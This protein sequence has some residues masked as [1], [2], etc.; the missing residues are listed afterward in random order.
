MLYRYNIWGLLAIRMQHESAA[1][2]FRAQSS[3][4][5]GHVNL[6]LAEEDGPRG[7]ATVV[8]RHRDGNKEPSYTLCY[9]NENL[10]SLRAFGSIYTSLDQ[11]SGLQGGISAGALIGYFIAKETAAAG[12]YDIAT[13]A[14]H[15]AALLSTD[16]RDLELHIRDITHIKQ[17]TDILGLPHRDSTPPVDVIEVQ[18]WVKYTAANN[19]VVGLQISMRFST[20]LAS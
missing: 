13:N 17:V 9:F 12:G 11:G 6:S 18:F 19:D 20:P 4:P 16:F 15:I 5:Y 14:P 7:D 1:Q 10:V 2:P 8:V 3:V